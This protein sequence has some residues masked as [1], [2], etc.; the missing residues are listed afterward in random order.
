MLVSQFSFDLPRELI[1]TSPAKPR[2]S[3]RLLVA[4][5]ILQD[6]SA[7]DIPSLLKEGDVMVFND[8]RVIPARLSGRY[9]ALGHRGGGDGK[10]LASHPDT[11]S[12]Q[13][14]LHKQD[15]PAIWRAFAKPARKLHIGGI[16]SIEADFYARILAKN[17]GEVTLEFNVS[18]AEFYK[19]LDKYGSPPLP[20]YIER[21]DKKAVTSDIED[22]QTIYAKHK[23][24]VAA[25]T[26]GLHF[27]DSLLEEITAKAVLQEFVTLHVGAG[28]FLP[29][30]VADTKDH[31]MHSEYGVITQKVADAINTAK[32]NG[33]RVV[34]V[35]T[36][37]LRLLESATDENG[38][39]NPFCGE[40]DIFITP[41]YKFKAVDV[42]ITN[43]HLPESTLFML[44]C[45]FAGM[46]KMQNVYRHAIE[47]KYRFYS[48]GDACFLL[49]NS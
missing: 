29:V 3:S 17:E 2:D 42:L 7:K 22:Y 19:M 38:V 47:Q 31:K 39:V 6:L 1:A 12:I 44:V 36:T 5:D 49:P 37:S 9:Q 13:I 21:V 45:A 46:D 25:P 43:F 23:G 35:G 48:Y 14:T 32:S 41:G 4:T 26:A 30:K 18:G 24:A 8:T 11:S 10:S 40:T 33:G 34:A 16:F 28:T 15:S 20:P 27:T